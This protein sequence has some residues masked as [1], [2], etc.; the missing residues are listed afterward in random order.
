MPSPNGILPFE[1]N[2]FEME[3]L[4][5]KLETE[6]DGQAGPGDEVRR[7]KKELTKLIQKVYSN[8]SAWETVLVSRHPNRPQTVDY[9]NLIFEEFVELHGDRAIGDDRAIRSGFARLG[10]YR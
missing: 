10:D 9:I 6:A 5:A 7:I 8:L 3:E 4:L 2:I 1:K